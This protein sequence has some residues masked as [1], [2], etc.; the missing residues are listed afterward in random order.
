MPRYASR[1]KAVIKQ[2]QHREEEARRE[3]AEALKRLSAEEDCLESLKRQ[4]GRALDEFA[5]KQNDGMRAQELD[6]YNR[7]ILQQI[8]KLDHHRNAIRRLTEQCENKRHILAQTTQE[9]KLIEKM[10][11]ARKTLFLKE[12]DKK[13]QYFQ[14][15]IAGRRKGE[16]DG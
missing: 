7:L 6:L 5:G 15:D 10:E 13:E 14:D 9:R 3:Y 11:E 4:I 12:L 1:F 16:R 2:R 8:E